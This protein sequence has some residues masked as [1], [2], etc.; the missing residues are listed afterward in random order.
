MTAG[1]AATA[2]A[3][4]SARGGIPTV[5]EREAVGE[6]ITLITG[7]QVVLGQDGQ[8]T[9]LIPAEGREN[10]PVR[11]T[12][13]GENLQVLPADVIPLLH[14][15][16]L[17]R[18]LF[19][20]TELSREQYRQVDGLRLIVSY[21]GT[22]QGAAELFADADPDVD[23]TLDAVDGEALTVAAED[24]PA[25]WAELTRPAEGV[26]TL[27]AAPGV[28]SIALDG[29]VTK[30]L[31]VS[32]PQ[33]GAPD[34]WE[35]G[36]DGTGITVAVLDTGIAKEH[37]DLGA[38]KIT[39]EQNFS[40]SDSATD[41]D[42]HGTHVASTVAGVGDP[43]NG[44]A[45]GAELFNGKVL[46]DFGSGWES[47]I[48]EGMQW[49]VDEGADIVSMSLGGYAGNEIDPMEEAVNTLSAES[50]ALFV[51]AAGNS[52]P[53]AGS[54]GT[55]GTADAALT[56]GAVDDADELAD[57]SSVGPRVRDGALKPDVTAPGVDI[58]AAGAENAAIWDYGTP[59]DDTHVAISGTS[60]ATPHVAG[61]AALVAQ[62][63]PEL[64][65]QQVKAVL[66]GSAITADGYSAIQ[67]GSGRIDVPA[68][69]SQT[70]IAEPANLS[71]GIVPFP[72]EDAEPVTKEL[73]YANL[74]DQDVTLQLSATATDPEGAQAPEGLFSL[75]ADEVTIPA[76]DTATV[77]VTANTS[78]GTLFGV[79]SLHITA[80][81]GTTTVTT[82]GAVE[83]EQEKF[84]LTV[85]STDRTGAP[86]DEFYASVLNL[87]TQESFELVGTEGS[88]TVRVPPGEYVVDVSLYQ[89]SEDGE[90]LAGVDWLVAPSVQVDED[91][92]VTADA[93]DAE[94]ID[95]TLED[96]TAEQTD[97]SPTV[98]F[99][100]EDG[101][102]LFVSGWSAAG[103]PEGLRTAQLGEAGSFS[104][105]GDATASWLGEEGQEYYGAHS[106]PDGF[107][108]GLTE[109]LEL[110]ET[111]QVNAA[112]GSSVEGSSG[113]LFVYPETSF[114]ASAWEHP[115]PRTAELYLQEG[116]A[117]GFDLYQDTP[118][119]WFATLTFVDFAEYA[120][121]EV[122]DLTINVGV[123]GPA[124]DEG[125]NIFRDGDTL[126]GWTNAFNDGAGNYSASDY[127]SA[128]TTLYRDGEEYAVVD[129][130]LDWVEFEVP[131][132]EADYELVTSI[133]RGPS[134]STV[135]T[136]VT[137]AF[138]FT[139]AS[140]D[141]LT[142]LPFSAVRYTPE[143]ALDST[144]PAGETL[145]VPVT[146]QGSAAD[147]PASLTVSASL[148]GGDT[149]EEADIVDGAVEIL[150]PDAGG[151]VSLR[152]EVEDNDGNT[153][154]QTII[155]AYRTT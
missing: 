123:H 73:T 125:G 137:S 48:I 121:G 82:A 78:A 101:E 54:V 151:T 149:W 148:D 140:T 87:E 41:R 25:L 10:I 139:S 103:L 36:F 19:D 152:A 106:N 107:Y 111:A 116:V 80:T 89:V 60:M 97:L 91:A 108:T 53:S 9:G 142:A 69:I 118:E 14:D 31:D 55:P 74:G 50:D 12:K 59:V 141:E 58:A 120:A 63:N 127:D 98:S 150:S 112:I 15:G 42:G 56:V 131:A 119:V 143:L 35:A 154:T 76:G 133:T 28:G 146:V 136:E 27:D 155:D 68:A 46:D 57:F 71:F 23:A 26:G 4:E 94:L 110:A 95:W 40:E 38:D 93:N 109:H 126:Y 81:D 83:R 77:E 67:Q 62:A 132:D 64:T 84:D 6:R 51:I 138:T 117:W 129:E 128:E 3:D 92:T 20:V 130:P 147:E 66:S 30:S 70:V 99:L 96:E 86:A 90:E 16:T 75:S 29:L 43:Y 114:F 8:V 2:G 49:A 115:L 144:T 122:Y 65:G 134:V 105:R 5:S 52:G 17:D 34:A 72:H 13:V 7:D 135:S 44:V 145:T 102:L 39:A 47:D 113:P 88:G 45:P 11:T 21:T 37:E 85:E 124:V 61:A 1:L 33:I 153:L 32:V 79:H 24:I 18:R 22:D 104:V 100:D